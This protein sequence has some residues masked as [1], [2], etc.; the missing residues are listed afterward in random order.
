MH[1]NELFVVH[2]IELWLDVLVGNGGDESLLQLLVVNIGQLLIVLVD[3]EGVDGVLLQEAHPHFLAHLVQPALHHV[4]DVVLYLVHLQVFLRRWVFR[5]LLHR[6]LGDVK[7][8]LDS[9]SDSNVLFPEGVPL[10]QL[11][12]VELHVRARPPPSLELLGPVLVER[13]LVELDRLDLGVDPGYA[14]LE[15]G[16]ELFLYLHPE[17]L[18]DGL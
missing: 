3:I 5:L 18:Q 4:Y 17:L 13:L 14:L 15:L 2:F 8:H 6:H 1:V 9:I 11:S 16:L 10:L 7:D 12:E